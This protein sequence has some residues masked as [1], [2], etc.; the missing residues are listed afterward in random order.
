MEQVMKE[1]GNLAAYL[2][3][4]S[5]MEIL[6]V[7]RDE[8]AH[9][10]FLGWLF[11]NTLTG[12]EA[13]SLFIS[14]LQEEAKIQAKDINDIKVVLEDFVEVKGFHG[15]VDIVMDVTYCYTKHQHII[16]ENKID[17]LEHKMGQG[18]KAVDAENAMWQTEGYYEYYSKL[19]PCAFVFLTRPESQITIPADDKVSQKGPQYNYFKWIDY[20]NLLDKVLAPLKNKLPVGSEERMRVDDYI[21]CLGINMTQ[22]NLI[23]V[24]EELKVLVDKVWDDAGNRAL[25]ERLK[26]KDAALNDFWETNKNLIQPLFKV[27]KYLYPESNDIKEIDKVVNGKDTTKYDLYYN[28]ELVNTNLSK[29]ALVKKV[30]ELYIYNVSN[31][32]E[33]VKAAFPPKLRM[34]EKGKGADPTSLSNQVVIQKSSKPNKWV[35][36]EGKSDWYVN[37]TG[38]DGKA[39]MNYF[40]N[41]AKTL[42]PKLQ[43][44]EVV[45]SEKDS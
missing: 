29:N 11:E 37:Q 26:E 4:K 44:H 19:K 28:G 21:R 7:D 3:R 13:T 5:M 36:L 45:P 27:L 8:C 33:D 32:L 20:Q 22:E 40:I 18:N 42:L 35:L 12:K 34:L 1:F 16:I 23:A 10:Q 17:S 38:W 9:S 31:N 30:V 25:F 6:G 2:S 43:I 15:R 39:M 14:M 41:H 24:S